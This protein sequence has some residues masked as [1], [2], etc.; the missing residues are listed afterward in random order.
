MVFL[1]PIAEINALRGG[2]FG[3]L[4]A[5][6][7]LLSAWIVHT[8]RGLGL[9]LLAVSVVATVMGWYW[10][11]VPGSSFAWFAFATVTTN[12]LICWPTHV[13][14]CRRGLRTARWRVTIADLLCLT[15]AV[16]I[17][18]NGLRSTKIEEAVMA[19]TEY[20]AGVGILFDALLLALAVWVATRRWTVLSCMVTVGGAT[21][22]LLTVR[23]IVDGLV[24]A[25]FSSSSSQMLELGYQIVSA[26][27]AYSLMFAAVTLL[28][29]LG[30]RTHQRDRRSA[31]SSRTQIGRSTGSI[32][33]TA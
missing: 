28:G 21:L 20:R 31:S 18:F 7:G 30:I 2:G 19:L 26:Y 27:L 29:L 11:A 15:A 23:L 14:S 32:D 16:A 22:T 6:L 5:Q 1:N 10:L 4:I 13:L 3:V 24:R 25:A 12:A 8:R 9:R 33:L 17:A